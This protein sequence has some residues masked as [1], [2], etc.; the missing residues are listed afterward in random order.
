M[1]FTIGNES[2]YKDAM[3]RHGEL[4]KRGRDD[5]ITIRDDYIGGYAFKT[6]QEAQKRID[7][8]YANEGF[9]VFGLD[10]DWEEDTY[11]NPDG[12]W[13]RHLLRDAKIIGL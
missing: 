6:K 9:A 12:Y 8:A 3:Q 2:L 7:E 11:E 10:A 13:W 1:I 4:L 5:G